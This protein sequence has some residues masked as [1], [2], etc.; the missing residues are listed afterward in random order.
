MEV[1][2]EI[3][4]IVLILLGVVG[5]V[6]PM[7]PGPQLAYIGLLV[8]HFMVGRPFSTTFLVVWFLVVVAVV[9]VDQLLPVVA[10]KKFGG[11]KYGTR[12][13][14]IGTIVGLFFWLIGVVF[15]PF[16]GAWSGEFLN[17]GDW[18]KAIKPAVGSF[19]GIVMSWVLKVGLCL[20]MGWYV[21]ERM[22]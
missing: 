11:S 2:W 13:A 9:V 17:I 12:G 20:V 7:L 4:G 10:T 3:I 22:I 5:C 14:V 19:I 8:F 18:K 1:A 6:V 15:G 16:F 21:V